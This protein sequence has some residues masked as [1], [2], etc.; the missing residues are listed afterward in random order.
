[1]KTFNLD[2]I[3]IT[4]IHHSAVKIKTKG[5][6]IYV[7]PYQ[8]TD[9]QADLILI[10]H[11]HPDHFDSGSILKLSKPGTK[12]VA[13]EILKEKIAGDVKTLK[14]GKSCEISNVKIST[15][16]SYNLSRPMHPKDKGYLGYIIKVS[17]KRIYVPG[18]TDKTPEMAALKN[19]DLAF[20]PIAGPMMDEEEASSAAKEFKPKIVVPYHYG[21]VIGGG[22]PEKFASLVGDAAQVEILE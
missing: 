15:I 5:L 3:Q 10:T 9:E 22:D 13:P 4:H 16:P 19:I 2:G 18:D 14:P 1:M 7:D 12:I 11:D 20:L 8:V 6:V 21:E 17:G